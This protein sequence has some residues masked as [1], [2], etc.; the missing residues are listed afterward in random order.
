MNAVLAAVES[1]LPELFPDGQGV[2]VS[3]SGGLDSMVLLHALHHAS[4]AERRLVAA[5]F[6]HLLRGE[7]SDADQL[8]VEQNAQ[9]LGL[10]I[11]CENW[12]CDEEAVQEFGLEMAAREARLEFLARV[13]KQHQCTVTAMGHH[14][15]DQAETFLWR[16]MRGAGGIGLGGMKPLDS[17]PGTKSLR[18]ARPFLGLGKH[19][20]RAFAKAEKILF[21]EDSSN[22][23]RRHLRN[24]IRHEL[25]PVLHAEFQPGIERAIEQSAELVRADAEFA[26]AMAR[27]WLG[28]LKR[29]SFWSLHTS[30]QRWVVWHQLIDQGVSPTFEMIEFLRKKPD[31]QFAVSRDQSIRLDTE[32]RLHIRK[33]TNMGYDLS[34]SEIRPTT[35]WT[36]EV[37]GGT[38]IRCRVTPQKPPAGAEE[39]LDAGRVGERVLLRHWRAGDRFVPIGGKEAKLQDLFTNAKVPASEKRR[40]VLACTEGGE[41][42]WVQGLRIGEV[43]KVQAET[44]RFLRWDCREL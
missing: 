12:S 43:A 31:G 41:I 37:F 36:E 1:A 38:T 19:E 11:E 32:G 25:L 33:T 18:I 7:A 16:M 24:R 29:S 42:F 3:V 39:L 23:D 14:R 40:R 35:S 15:D 30:L 20:L 17:F 21:R 26:R 44:R 13:A 22:D 10:K 28:Q 5:H 4:G 9:R 27:K 6:N 8:L 34:E 2:V